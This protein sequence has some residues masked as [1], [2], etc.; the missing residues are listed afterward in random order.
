MTL[1]DRLGNGLYWAG[2]FFTV[3]FTAFALM[4]LNSDP[5][6]NETTIAAVGFAIL[7]PA[8]WGFGAGP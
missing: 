7:S 6:S 1:I 4:P 8:C 3:L 5:N 2:C